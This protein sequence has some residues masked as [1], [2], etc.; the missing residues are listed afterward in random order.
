MFSFIFCSDGEVKAEQEN[1]E[2]E[3]EDERPEADQLS[4]Q[5]KELKVEDS[6][7]ESQSEPPSGDTEKSQE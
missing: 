7:D 5:I 4:Q 1:G 6:K 2:V 3:K